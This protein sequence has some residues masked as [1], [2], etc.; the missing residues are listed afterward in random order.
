MD[1]FISYNSRDKEW[2]RGE[3][4]TRIEQAGLKAFI[5]FRDFTRGAP[6]IE[7]VKRGLLECRKTLLVL[8]PEYIKDEWS[9]VEY[10]MAE[11]LNPANRDLRIIP[12]LKSDVKKPFRIAA[13]TH[14]DFTN[15][16][17]QDLAWRQLLTALGVLSDPEPSKEPR[18]DQ[19]FQSR[20][21]LHVVADLD[22]VSPEVL[23]EL[24]AALDE[25]HRAHGGGGLEIRS[26]HTGSAAIAG[27]ST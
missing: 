7:E 18:H 6:V 19:W 12:L 1:V 16:A 5:D 3:L 9:E 10:V 14:I 23:V 4:L 26:A 13:L 15:G 24:I 11:T 20:S 8:T 22:V 21:D 25:I 17:D 2:V 27:V